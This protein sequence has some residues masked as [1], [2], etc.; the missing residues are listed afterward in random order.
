MRENIT[1]INE[2]ANKGTTYTQKGVKDSDTFSTI[3]TQNASLVNM[4]LLKKLK[5]INNNKAVSFYNQSFR[6]S[7]LTCF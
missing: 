6:H 2:T 7:L 3:Q 1:K 4:R 5:T